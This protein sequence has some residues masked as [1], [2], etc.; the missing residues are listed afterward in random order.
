MTH[1]LKDEAKIFPFDIDLWVEEVSFA[2]FAWTDNIKLGVYHV[3][4]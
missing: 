4:K 3:A 2:T 1:A